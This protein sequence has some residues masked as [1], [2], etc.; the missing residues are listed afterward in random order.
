M[1]KL[2]VGACIRAGWEIFKKRPLI[3]IGAFVIAMAISGIA[4][5]LLDP[6]EGAP[7]TAATTLMSIASAI[8][9]I[10]V[11]LGLVTFAIRAHDNVET[12]KIAD[13]WNPSVFLRYL[14]AQI[15][16]GLTVVVGLI[17][18]IVPGV[19]AAL[20]LM[21]ASYLVIDKGRGPLEAYKESWHM[22]KGHKMELFLLV[23]AVIG[24]NILGLLALVVGLLVTIPV[25]MLAMVHAYRTLAGTSSE[26]TPVPVA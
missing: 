1:E 3:I 10:F 9:G 22:T 21:F 8:I 13:L 20:G 14:G 4:S 6:G 16:V 24:L 2:S 19:I 26:P 17:L 5:S 25:S 11:E 15:L 12:A 18:V 7:V 23:L